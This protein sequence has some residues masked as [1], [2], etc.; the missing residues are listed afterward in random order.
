M[1]NAA[2]RQAIA[3][4]AKTVTGIKCTPN[5]RQ[6]TKPGD[7]CVRLANR[8]RSENGYGFMDTWQVWL[9]LPQDLVAGET[10][11]DAHIDTIIGAL[12][13]QLVITTVT[14]A[15]LLF[16]QNPVNGVIFEGVREDS[17]GATYL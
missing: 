16:G 6:L 1:T 9:A 4:A 13:D 14:P 8:A 17:S 7:A 3:D 15:D 2:T 11:L 5:Y 10:Y 12:S